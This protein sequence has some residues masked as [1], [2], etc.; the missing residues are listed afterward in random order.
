MQKKSADLSPKLIPGTSPRYTQVLLF[1]IRQKN[2]NFRDVSFFYTVST[3]NYY[4]DYYL[5]L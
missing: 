2:I 1:F 5:T 4:Y 3:A